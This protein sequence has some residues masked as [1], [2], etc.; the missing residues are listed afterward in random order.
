VSTTLHRREF[1]QS[2]KQANQLMHFNTAGE[3]LGQ[4]GTP[5]AKGSLNYPGAAG[6]VFNFSAISTNGTIY[7]YTAEEGNHGLHRWK[8]FSQ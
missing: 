7:L 4:F 6:N 1:W 2:D 8:V 3:F 5:K